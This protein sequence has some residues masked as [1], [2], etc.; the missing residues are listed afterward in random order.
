[1]KTSIFFIYDHET[2][3]YTWRAD[4]KQSDSQT[5]TH[6]SRLISNP[7]YCK[8]NDTVLNRENAAIIQEL[9]AELMAEINREANNYDD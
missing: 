4:F 7:D 9:A 2:N 8:E 6:C 3:K 1:M 5:M